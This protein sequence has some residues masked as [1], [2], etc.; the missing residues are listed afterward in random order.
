[1]RQPLIRDND[2][3]PGISVS[4]HSCEYSRG[5]HVSP[6]AHGADQLIYASRGVMQVAAGPNVWLIP[7]YFGLWIPA[8]TSHHIRMAE[9]VSMRTLYLRPA[10]AACGRAPALLHVGPLLR[11]LII[12]IVRVGALRYRNPV[13][14]AL[15]VLLVAELNRASPVPLA[16]AL[17][18]DRRALAV[19]SR[20]VDNPALRTSLA[21]MCRSAAVS[22][23]T[24]E[25]IFR[26]EIGTDFERW[27]QQVRLMKATELLVAGRSVK[28]VA[29]D[30]GYRQ[31]RAFVAL[32]RETFGATPRVWMRQVVRPDQERHRS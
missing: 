13:E 3:A 15:R 32:F 2:P 30:V 29:L 6:H 31:P 19:A 18:T 7:P 22:V 17:P 26:R 20:I 8:R 12:E 5:A 23:R 25:R 27:R 28:Q 9:S 14:R 4:T 16:V 1:M 10:L 21:G 24:L 11:E